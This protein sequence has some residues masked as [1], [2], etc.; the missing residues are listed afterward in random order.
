MKQILQSLKNG[1]TA[2][3]DVPCP[4]IRPGHVL[5]RTQKSLIS[6]GTE[7]MLVN[8]GKASP[9]EKIRQQPDKVRMVFDKIKTEGLASTIDAVRSKLDQLLPMA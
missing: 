3:M 8:F 9:L 2:V 7:K 5:I 1:D 6:S 4:Q